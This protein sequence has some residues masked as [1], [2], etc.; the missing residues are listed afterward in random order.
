VTTS[1]RGIISTANSRATAA[2]I[3]FTSSMRTTACL[4]K[5]RE[6]ILAA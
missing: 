5:R 4:D 1:I 3:S 2:T 6:F